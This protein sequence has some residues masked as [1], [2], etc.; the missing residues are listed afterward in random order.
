LWSA[1]EKRRHLKIF[2]GFQDAHQEYGQC[3]SEMRQAEQSIEQSTKLAA[4]LEQINEL[5]RDVDE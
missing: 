1:K 3:K 2:L 5:F 4:Q